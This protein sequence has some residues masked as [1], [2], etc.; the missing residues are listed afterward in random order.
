MPETRLSEML[1][2]HII[3]A[4]DE[5]RARS[6]ADALA[7]RGH[8]FVRIR[9]HGDRWRL[10]SLVDGEAPDAQAEHWQAESEAEVVAALARRHGAYRVGSMVAQRETALRHH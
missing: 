6:L 9:P 8:C 3:D 2:T 10:E 5:D 7:E 1:H 4:P